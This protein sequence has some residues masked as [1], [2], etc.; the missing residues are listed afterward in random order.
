MSGKKVWGTI[1]LVSLGLVAGA[2]LADET[3]MKSDQPVTDSYITTKVKAEL[4]KDSTTKARH[5]HVTTKD[6]NV[7]LKGMV[8]SDDEKQ[9]AEQDASGVKGVTHVDNELTIKAQAQ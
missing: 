2:A 8:A 7:M 6:G 3:N 4:A 1:T 5:I 9:K